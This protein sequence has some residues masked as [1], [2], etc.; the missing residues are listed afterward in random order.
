M[1]SEITDENRER[2]KVENK[3]LYALLQSLWPCDNNYI[4]V[5]KVSKALNMVKYGFYIARILLYSD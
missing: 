2:L 4:P 3:N 5:C 1:G